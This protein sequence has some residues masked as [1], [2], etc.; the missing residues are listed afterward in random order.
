MR[1]V[2]LHTH[3]TFSYGDGFGPVKAHVAR[4]AQLGM[5]AV[6]LTEHG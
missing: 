6:A 3:S 2:S 1:Y 4:V 5:S